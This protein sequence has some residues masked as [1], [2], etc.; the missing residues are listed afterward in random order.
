MAGAPCL[1]LCFILFSECNLRG[2]S[3]CR[4][5]L[6]LVKTRVEYAVTQRT[7]RCALTVD[8]TKRGKE[9]IW[10]EEFILWISIFL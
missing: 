2:L 1:L 7:S 5:I 8:K 3:D 10:G 4:Q 6:F 9:N